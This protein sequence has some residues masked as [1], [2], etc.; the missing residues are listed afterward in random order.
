V[1]VGAS[2]IMGAW[3][4]QILKRVMTGKRDK[5]KRAQKHYLVRR[6]KERGEQKE[7]DSQGGAERGNFLAVGKEGERHLEK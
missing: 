6:D 2:V 4:C 5:E 3:A 1:K 7:G